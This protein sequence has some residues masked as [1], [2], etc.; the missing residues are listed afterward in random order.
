MSPSAVPALAFDR[1]AAQA[2]LLAS[3]SPTHVAHIDARLAAIHADF[4][5][6]QTAGYGILERNLRAWTQS[7]LRGEDI[8]QTVCLAERIR[9]RFQAFVL[10]GI[11]GSDLG[12]RTLLDLLDDPFHNQRAPEDR[13]G[14]PEVYF[15]GDTFDPRRLLA[16]LDL[17]YSRGILGDT[18]FNVVSKSGETGETIAA[19]LVIRSYLAE[20]GIKD[21]EPQVIATTG[22]TEQSVLHQMNARSPFFGILPVPDGVGGRFSFASPVGLLPLAV[23][24]AVSSPDERVA[25][26]L[27]GFAEAHTEFLGD[28]TDSVAFSLAAWL[29]LA[30]V[31]CRRSTLIFCNYADDARLGDWFTQLYEESVQ[32][33]GAGLN[34][35]PTRGPTGNHSILNGILR[36]PAD[37]IVLFVRWSDIGADTAIPCGS[38]IG[39]D[40]RFFEGLPMSAVQ[41]ASCSATCSD[42]LANGVPAAILTVGRRDTRH[43]FRLLRTLMDMV[44]IKGRLQDLDRRSDGAI[45]A[46][47]D[48]TYRQDGVQS[49]KVGTRQIAAKMQ[50][51]TQ[52]R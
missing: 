20:R 17:L 19:A 33:R 43:A 8:A 52:S 41:A 45:D 27:A 26:A 44:A 49:Y 35:I 40:L 31:H 13:G 11:G 37:K 48:L 29:H 7:H 38:G 10:V 9:A 2:M 51:S 5:S 47:T 39:G 23:T 30:E 25:D 32:E 42:Y 21:W 46:S 24:S 36:G 50:K 18:C 16:L 1:S 28:V 4:L 12:G 15:T 3:A 34:V 22:R 6:E 14:A